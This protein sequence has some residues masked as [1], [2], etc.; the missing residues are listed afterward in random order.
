MRSARAR[1][2]ICEYCRLP[3]V[4]RRLRFQIEHVISRQHG[5]GDALGNLA[6][7]CGRC[8]RHQG[9]NIAGIDGATGQLI[10]LFNPRVDRWQ[11]HFRWEGALAVGVTPI[12][13]ATI[14]VLAMNHPE[15]VA[16]RLEMMDSG[17]FPP[18]SEGI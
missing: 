10:R 17:R 3:Q 4:V 18:R 7:A 2:H 8:N 15:D 11:D 9:P 16:I 1:G 6:L 14:E 12:G 5:G 13:R